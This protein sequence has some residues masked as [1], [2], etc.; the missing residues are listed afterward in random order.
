M[1]DRLQL[2]LPIYSLIVL[3][4]SLGIL[5]PK[6]FRCLG[7]S[8]LGL[9]WSSKGW[10]LWLNRLIDFRLSCFYLHGNLV[11]LDFSGKGFWPTITSIGSSTSSCRLLWLLFK[12]SQSLS[13]D[14][15]G[16]VMCIPTWVSKWVC[17]YFRGARENEKK[18]KNCLNRLKLMLVLLWTNLV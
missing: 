2:F 18:M 17:V 9:V 5:F 1:E 8:F 7:F 16:Y 3:L 13:F 4:F 10:F 15:M 14:L 6:N 11:F 12:V